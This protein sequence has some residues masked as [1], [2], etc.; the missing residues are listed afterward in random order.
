M[1][2]FSRSGGDPV[3]LWDIRRMDSV[4]SEI[5]MTSSNSARVSQTSTSKATAQN[6]IEAVKWSSDEPGMLSV[7]IGEIV[8]DFDT[9]SGS[10]PVLV[11]SN[12]VLQGGCIKDLA[13]YS[14]TN[15][16][17][18]A[19]EHESDDITDRLVKTLYPRRMLVVLE[20]RTVCDMAKH[21]GLAPLAISRR[22]GRL[23]HA[24]GNTV[25]VGSTTG[26]PAGMEN[27][28]VV[29][30]EDISAT[31]MRRARCSGESRYSSDALKNIQMLVEDVV[32]R[33][34]DTK[35]MTTSSLSLLRL[36][37]WTDRVENLAIE[38]EEAEGTLQWPAKGLQDAGVVHLLGVDGSTPRDEVSYSP[39]L[40]CN[41]FV[42]LGRR[43]SL[44]ACGWAG[45][46]GLD[47]V[48]TE[49]R[50]LGEPERAAALAVWHGDIGAAVEALHTAA[51]AIRTSI[52]ENKTNQPYATPQYAE[53]LSLI[54][55]CVAGYSGSSSS[56]SNVWQS[57]CSTL[58][59]RDDFT[60]PNAKSSR[61]VYLRALCQFLLHVGSESRFDEVLENEVLAYGDR[62]AFACLY[63]DR[64]QLRVYLENCLGNC[65]Q[66]G[67]LEGL[68]IS[69]LS[70]DGIK[71]LE[72]FV[73]KTCDVQ[74]A[75]LIVSR[76]ALP[77]DWVVERKICTEWIEAYRGLLN[78]WQM[79]QSRASF[80]I[81][82]AEALRRIK[83]KG[84]DFNTARRVPGRRQGSRPI[85]SDALTS[86]PAGLDARCNYCSTPLGL[87]RH[88]GNANQWLSKMKPVLSCCP[89]CRKPLPRCAICLLSLGAL[90]PYVELTRERSRST[91]RSGNP[92]NSSENLSALPLA[93]WF[94]WCMS[95]KHGGHAH[96]LVGWFA[97][98]ETC[99]VSG[100]DCRCQFDGIQ[101]LN[102]PAL[103]GASL[104]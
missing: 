26:G 59:S 44:I 23:V 54:A 49:C 91:A 96:H 11:R 1:A 74:T 38:T 67:N 12:Q 55:M 36:W 102:R 19:A 65:Q 42:S 61:I 51:N 68:L 46:F 83:S 50:A 80:D 98:H 16:I 15:I 103:T 66:W 94:T 101:R 78:T 69:G 5:K 31:M 30:D 58:L 22:D 57:A 34:P 104:D 93:E 10:R 32:S 47:S 17:P 62:V 85:D 4:V 20:D 60:G 82:R 2:T 41:V 63:L 21:G 79:W 90:N 43:L 37:S 88:E 81:H 56:Q 53:T 75:A 76:V 3:K 28:A 87:R 8:Q 95:C 13:L 99:P 71:I 25:W 89:Q 7:A 86:I 48:I 29:H 84:N 40:N 77:A 33:D 35:D 24:L 100:C 70:K 18:V 92:M 14:S 45:R 97:N 52:S 9:S 39:T 6:R 64:E 73:D 72:A 27:S